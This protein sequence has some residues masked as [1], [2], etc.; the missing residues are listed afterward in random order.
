MRFEDSTQININDKHLEKSTSERKEFHQKMKACVPNTIILT[1]VVYLTVMATFRV[2]GGRRKYPTHS[3]PYLQSNPTTRRLQV[4]STELASEMLLRQELE[5]E[6]KM[7]NSRPKDSNTINKP[8][9]S[10]AKL[11]G[12]YGSF[13][14]Y[15]RLGCGCGGGCGLLIRRCGCPCWGGC[16]YP[17]GYPNVGVFRGGFGINVGR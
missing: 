14:G 4:H 10:K 3:R 11:L 1:T 6:M 13:G 17:I 15:G 8:D 12:G 2:H 16:S 5:R 7:M 9:F